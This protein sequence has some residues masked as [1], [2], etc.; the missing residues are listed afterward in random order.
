MTESAL[1][2]QILLALGSRSDCRVWRNNTGRLLNP[3]S[4]R[5]ISFGLKGSAD[6][7]GVLRGGRF[8]AI[9]VKTPLGRLRPEQE[10]FREMVESLAGLYVVARCVEDAVRAVE[11]AT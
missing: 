2:N 11:R 7:F 6:I 3:R 9:E 10:C 5:W 4:G 8:L 1:L